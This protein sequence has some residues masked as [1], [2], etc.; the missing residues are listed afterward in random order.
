MH[1]GIERSELM[2]KKLVDQVSGLEIVKLWYPPEGEGII[3]IVRT[4]KGPSINQ[5]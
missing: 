5:R 4:G 2:W 1:G 3:Q